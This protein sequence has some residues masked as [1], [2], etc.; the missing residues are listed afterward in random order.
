MNIPIINVAGEKTGEM[1]VP[2]TIWGQERH[3]S[4]EF[5]SILQS[6]A[7]KRRGCASTKTRAEVRG[8]GKKPWR[9]KGTGRARHG[10]RRSPIWTGG[11]ITFGPKPRSFA[12]DLNKKVRRLALFSALSSKVAEDNTYVIEGVK[13]TELKIK[14]A[15]EAVG[16]KNLDNK[17]LFIFDTEKNG[18]FLTAFANSKTVSARPVNM[19]STDEILHSGKVILTSEAVESM[20]EVWA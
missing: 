9:Q 3:E 13:L 6:R 5:I 1:S 14:V 8:G 11:G 15:T 2:D 17:T 12:F 19:L 18:D 4:C 7:G 20:K 10:S 16:V